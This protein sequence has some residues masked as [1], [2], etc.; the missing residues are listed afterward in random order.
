M[1]RRACSYKAV[2][3]PRVAGT[4]PRGFSDAA[5]TR[6][7]LYVRSRMS[8]IKAAVYESELFGETRVVASSL[9]RRVYTELTRVGIPMCVLCVGLQG[10]RS[11]VK[12]DDAYC[13]PKSRP[14][15]SHHLPGAPVGEYNR[16]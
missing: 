7:H 2:E 15:S 10:A 13:T 11:A 12:D 4:R 16:A 14:A 6:P 1:L 3:I 5:R 8:S 9:L